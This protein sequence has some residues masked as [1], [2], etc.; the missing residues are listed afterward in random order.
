MKRYQFDDVFGGVANFEV[1]LAALDDGLHPDEMAAFEVGFDDFVVDPDLIGVD[2][3][4]AALDDGLLPDGIVAFEVGFDDFGFDLDLIGVDVDLAALDLFGP[5]SDGIAGVH[6]ANLE[7]VLDSAAHYFDFELFRAV[8][9][10]Q[11]HVAVHFAVHSA[12]S[13]SDLVV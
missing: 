6:A 9:A 2:F 7:R 8:H 13:R 5:R 11:L 10:A 3:D 12:G 1:D 4:L